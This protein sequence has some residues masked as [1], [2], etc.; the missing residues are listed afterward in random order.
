MAQARLTALRL[1]AGHRYRRF[2]SLQQMRLQI[3]TRVCQGR[4]CGCRGFALGAHEPSL[5]DAFMIA[6]RVHLTD[7]LWQHSDMCEIVCLR[8]FAI[9]TP[10]H[11]VWA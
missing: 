6:F 9:L 2:S 8:A 10:F 7:G 3:K 11:S 1:A 5:R 4:V